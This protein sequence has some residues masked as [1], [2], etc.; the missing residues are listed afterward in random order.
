VERTAHSA[1]SVLMR[2]SLSVGR[3]SPG[4]FGIMEREIEQMFDF[5]MTYTQCFKITYLVIA[6]LFIC[7][8]GWFA[9]Y[10]FISAEEISQKR[11]QSF[12]WRW[13]QIWVNVFGQFL[14][15]FVG[16]FVFKKALLHGV[17]TFGALDYLALVITF[18]GMSGYL[19]TV[20]AKWQPRA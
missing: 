7:F 4:A 6:I 17:D 10:I 19:P 11:S 5:V 16:Y 1:G 2:G 18:L 3:R 9:I 15:W 20:L 8:Y 12:S 14:G 13:H